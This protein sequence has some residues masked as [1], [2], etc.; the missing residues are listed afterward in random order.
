MHFFYKLLKNHEWTKKVICTQK[1]RSL[2]MAIPRKCS[3]CLLSNLIQRRRKIIIKTKLQQYWVFKGLFVFH[4]IKCRHLSWKYYGSNHS[5]GIKSSSLL[6][7]HIEHLKTQHLET[8]FPATYVGYSLTQLNHQ[9]KAWLK[10]WS[11]QLGDPL[12]RKR[13]WPNHNQVKFCFIKF[14]YI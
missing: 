6:N 3:S 12:G 14:S 7:N 4:F 11:F 1:K 13:F 5:F 2:Y 8:I 10:W 9:T